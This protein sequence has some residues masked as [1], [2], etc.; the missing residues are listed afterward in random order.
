[1]VQCLHAELHDYDPGHAQ[2]AGA[3]G[4]LGWRL[5]ANGHVD[6][7]LYERG[8]IDTDIPFDDLRSRSNVTERAKAAVDFSDFFTHIRIGCQK[9]MLDCHPEGAGI[10]NGVPHI[11]Q[12]RIW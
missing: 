2:N 6:K 1:V 10:K 12:F 9:H 8:Q 11:D 3:G 5:L 4:R 7:L